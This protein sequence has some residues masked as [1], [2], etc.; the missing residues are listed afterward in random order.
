MILIDETIVNGTIIK[1]YDGIDFNMIMNHPNDGSEGFIYFFID[2]WA[3]EVKAH[4]RENKINSLI[5]DESNKFDIND[6]N[7]NCISIY[8]T[9][10]QT[11]GIYEIIR[12]KVDQ[13]VPIYNNW[14]QQM[15]IK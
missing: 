9:D 1:F 10:G 2:R 13:N 14:S 7:N 8:Q 11:M 6:I 15:K 5:G 4:E 12:K 3:N